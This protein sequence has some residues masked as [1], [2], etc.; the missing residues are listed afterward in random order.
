MTYQRDPDDRD[1]NVIDPVV[2]KP[3]QHQDPRDRVRSEGG[4]WPILPIALALVF[5][6]ILSFIFTSD[7]TP[8]PAYRATDVESPTMPKTTPAQPN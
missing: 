8:G 6:V 5:I 4:R 1:P 7:Q 3:V 2:P